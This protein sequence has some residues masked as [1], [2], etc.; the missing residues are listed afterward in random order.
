MMKKWIW[1]AAPLVL[2]TAPAQ[3]AHGK[4]HHHKRHHAHAAAMNYPDSVMLEGKEYKVCKPGMQDDCAQP[5][6]AGLGHI[7]GKKAKHR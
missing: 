3:A 7:A 6:Q 1:V 4:S 5:S 2:A